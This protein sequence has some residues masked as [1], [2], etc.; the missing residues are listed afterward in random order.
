MGSR[1]VIL[2]VLC[3]VMAA[4]FGLHY[5]NEAGMVCHG[6][7]RGTSSYFLE[8]F[9]PQLGN[10]LIVFTLIWW[11]GGPAVSKY[12]AERK[13]RIEREIEECGRIKAQAS[14]RAEEAEKRL[15]ELEEE[16]ARMRRS[17][18]TATAEECKR[19]EDDAAAQGERLKRD[20]DMA[21]ELQSSSA[22]RRFEREVVDASIERARREIEARLAKDASLRNGLIDRGIAS[23]EL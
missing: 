2:F 17:Y 10:T 1:K 12:L 21:Y 23:F 6:V 3:V 9:A 8:T 13:S 7:C 5:L 22:R 18:E 14:A 15:V 20:A 16:K 19:I 4:A 11:F